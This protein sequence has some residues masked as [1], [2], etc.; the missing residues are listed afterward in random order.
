MARLHRI[1][2]LA[3]VASTG[4]G[5]FAS[6]VVPE[7]A[8]SLALEL[9]ITAVGGTPTISFKFQ[10]SMDEQIVTDASSDWFDLS[11]LPS[12]SNTEVVVQTKTGIAVYEQ[13][14]EIARRP[15]RKIRLNVTV[16]TNVTFESEALAARS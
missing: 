6:I 15:I 14:T 8:I 3:P 13:M 11:V 5:A 10:G 1:G 4:T 16:N 9:E 7:D 12:D 2:N